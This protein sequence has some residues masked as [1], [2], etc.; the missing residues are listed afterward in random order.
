MQTTL[1][2]LLALAA[3]LSTASAGNIMGFNYGSQK[4]D[5]ESMF[6]SDFETS[7]KTAQNLAGTN[8][9]FNSARLYT[10]IQAYSTADVISAIP[11]ALATNTTLLLGLW[12]SGTGFENEITALKTAIS[13]YGQ[14]FAD[15]VTGI[16]VGSEDLYRNSP[17]SIANG[18]D[19]GQ[20][21]AT[22]VS[23]IKEV[24]SAISGTV[25]SGASVGHVDTW[26]AWTNSSNAD[27]ITQLDWVGVDE[28][29]YWQTTDG[30]SVENGAALFQ[31]AIDATKA[32][33]G[34]KPIWITETGWAVNG[35]SEGEAVPGADTAKTYWD[36]VGCDML[37]GQYNT[38]WYTLTETGATPDFSVSDT[39]ANT[40]PLYDLTCSAKSSSNTTTSSST[41]SGS[42]SSGNGSSSTGSS[43]TGSSGTVSSGFSVATS[44]SSG[45]NSS[46]LGA[47]ATLA[48]AAAS[49]TASA[50]SGSGSGSESTALAGSSGGAANSA[51][52]GGLLVAAALAIFIL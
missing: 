33:V 8:G 22:L 42:S 52:F 27:V 47:N 28:Y 3:V 25:L 11:A 38:Y 4:Q 45:G 51:S 41:S 7:F 17:T 49:K 48:T 39:N 5:L 1:S 44:T 31:K 9:A 43:G 2:Q 15:I 19:I 30:N 26:D 10:M 14:D 21:P 24:R 46:V 32:V 40:T 34:D 12:A 50:T 29:P 13:T 6:Q 18:G 20:D 36:T 35:A 16:S 37:F 23:Y